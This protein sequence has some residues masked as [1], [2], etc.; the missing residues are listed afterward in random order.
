MKT[1]ARLSFLL[2]PRLAGGGGHRC[3]PCKRFRSKPVEP[4]S[5]QFADGSDV[6]VAKSDIGPRVTPWAR[7]TVQWQTAIGDGKQTTFLAET[8]SPGLRPQIARIDARCVHRRRAIREA[9]RSKTNGSGFMARFCRAVC[10]AVLDRNF[11]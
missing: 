4:V 8:D 3:L 6:M 11:S 10:G 2:S 1:A 9:K 7:V 5:A